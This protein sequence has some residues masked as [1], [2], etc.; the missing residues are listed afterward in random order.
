MGRREWR[1]VARLA[2]ETLDAVEQ[3]GLFAADVGAG[4]AT[5]LNIERLTAAG[6][7]AA[8]QTG[9]TSDRNRVLEPAGRERP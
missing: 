9:I 8:E 5:N 3:R 2:A 1:L 6:N 7:I 4:A